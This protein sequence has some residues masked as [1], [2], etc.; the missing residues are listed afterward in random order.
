MKRDLALCRELLLRAEAAIGPHG[1]T[2]L[3]CG[4]LATAIG[5]V[6]RE[7][8]GYNMRQLVDAGFFSKDTE[9]S[10]QG[11]VRCSGLS[12]KGSEWLDSVRDPKVWHETKSTVDKVGSWTFGIVKDVATAY[13]K[14][15]I[16]KYGITL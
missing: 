12:W 15:E 6:D 1:K 11:D 5:D 14:G 2:W 3:L 16:S 10:R 4:S 7:A 9:V 8:V 13:I